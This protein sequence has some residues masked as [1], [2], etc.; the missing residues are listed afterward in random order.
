M[1]KSKRVAWLR[2]VLLAGLS[3]ALMSFA[4]VARGQQ[5]SSNQQPAIPSKPSEGATPQT[6]SSSGIAKASYLTPIQGVQGVLAE[7]L[8]G[9]VLATQAA[10]ET[11]NPASSIK[12][13][14]AL[15]ALQTFGPDYRYMSTVWTSGELD[16]STGT[17]N[18]DL[19]LS[20]RDPSFHYEHAVMLA[21]EL[22]LLGIRTINGNLIVAPTFTLNFDWSAR[23]SGLQLYDV[24][25]SSRRPATAT[26]AWI[27]ERNGAGDAAS[28]R[29]TPS[30][31][32]KGSL[33]VGPAPTRASLLFT[34][35]S[36]RLVDILKVLLCYS[37]NFM[38]ER[39]GDT[40]GGP[41]AVRRLLIGRLKLKPEEIRLASLSGL[42]VN[43]V[44]PR[45]MMTI[46]R[47]LRL[48]LARN[49]LS[50][51]DIMPVAG[52]DPGTLEDRYTS[53]EQ[54]GSVIAK[55]GTL[56]ST[57]RGASSLVGQMQTK[58]GTIV[59]F[60]IFNQRG[61]VLRFRANQDE[62][63][64]SIQSTLGGPAPFSYHPV[65]LA[66]RLVDTENEAAK[67]KIEY[68]PKDN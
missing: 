16:Q 48:E 8:D 9:R 32:I 56:I 4:L 61:G 1:G 5:S 60:V 15:A 52:I 26:K 57:D 18:G 41:Q 22:N 30:V 7:T 59:L 42:G 31:T 49:K 43:R 35:R 23:R 58:S 62:I 11:F 36:S 34:H 13:A 38:A 19:I 51:S 47:A 50:P 33:Q 29:V 25:D 67:V 2:R 44:T 37:N 24:L 55:T 68:E 28:L 54:R 39:I 66:M 21:R 3:V 45:A 20:G 53:P 63:V 46:F 17:L 6:S 10:D 27:D 64:T 14:T 65:A 40:L 12:L